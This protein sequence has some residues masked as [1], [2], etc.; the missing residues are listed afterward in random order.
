MNN[1]AIQND[2]SYYRRTLSR[3]KMQDPEGDDGV[4]VTNEEANRMS[5]FYAS[6]TPMLKC[7]CDT[8][9][10]FVSSHPHVGVH[11]F[12]DYLFAHVSTQ[13]F[14]QI[15]PESTTDCLGAMAS[16]CRIMIETPG[17]TARFHSQNTV[18]FC[19]VCTRVGV[20][21]VF[22]LFSFGYLSL[23]ILHNISRNQRVMVGCIIVY[24]H[25]HALG[26]FTKK[27]PWIDVCCFGLLLSRLKDAD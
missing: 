3:M 12:I 1:P 8:S 10:R 4:A 15:D 23:C 11:L 2:F 27:N 24:D 18:L 6:P 14:S 5:L 21:F 16:V 25:V 19:Q 22:A 20:F 9:L 26:A 13:T 17:L 7:I